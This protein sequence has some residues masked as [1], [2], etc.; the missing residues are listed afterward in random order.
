MA[1]R[2][3]AQEEEEDERLACGLCTVEEQEAV[4]RKHAQEE[5]DEMVACQCAMEKPEGS[6]PRGVQ[7]S[8]FDV[9][10]TSASLEHRR[11]YGRSGVARSSAP[12][13]SA[14]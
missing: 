1:S 7:A 8:D 12:P 13:P 10:D 2:K 14:P 9:F 3:R 5:E 4:S 6:K 11:R